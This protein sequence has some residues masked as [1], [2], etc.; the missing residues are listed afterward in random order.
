[1]PR[2]LYFLNEQTADD[3]A[4]EGRIIEEAQAK[5]VRNE[6]ARQRQWSGVVDLT[7]DNGVWK[8]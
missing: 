4:E 5:A 1:M 3:E 7:F 6:Q 2:V 8:E